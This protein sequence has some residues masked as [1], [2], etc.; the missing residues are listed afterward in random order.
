MMFADG[1]L[2]A[3]TWAKYQAYRFAD[4][5]TVNSQHQRERICRKFAWSQN[6]LR[7]IWNGVDLERYSPAD[8]GHR[9]TPTGC[10]IVAAGTIEHRKNAF[11]LIKATRL[12]VDRGAVL[13]VSWAGKVQPNADG[14]SEFERCRS[15]I[16][17]LGLECSWNWL[18]EC[19]AMHALYSRF[20][21]LVHPSLV[22]GLPNVVCEGLACGLPILASSVGDHAL[23]ADGGRNGLLFDPHQPESIADALVQAASLPATEH[24]KMAT[25]ARQFAESRLSRAA[26][27]DAYEQ[28]MLS[29]VQV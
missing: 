10:S 28:L 19:S 24:A 22:E 13:S 2:S 15:L 7:A 26:F 1:S 3:G 5:I 6:K 17:D 21:Y 14:R 23:L 11:N 9:K 20:D 25:H 29:L 16:A 27:V 4:A 18:G 8:D 12:A